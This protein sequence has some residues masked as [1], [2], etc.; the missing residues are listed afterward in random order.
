MQTVHPLRETLHHEVHARPYERMNAPLLLSHIALVGNAG[1]AEREHVAKLL[2]SRQLA[3]PADGASHLSA[4]I[5]GLRLRWEKHGEFHTCTF[6]KQL[7]EVPEGFD[8]LP[9]DGVAVEGHS[10]V[11]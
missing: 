6:W 10:A 7:A 8:R 11:N 5:G 1:G 4:D 2:E 9:T 3:V